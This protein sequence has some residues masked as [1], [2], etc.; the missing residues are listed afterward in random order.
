M[1]SITESKIIKFLSRLD[2]P[3]NA[4]KIYLVLIKNGPASRYKRAKV[5]GVNRFR[6]NNGLSLEQHYGKTIDLGH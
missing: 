2:V 1:I 6:G 5:F 4:A 3:V